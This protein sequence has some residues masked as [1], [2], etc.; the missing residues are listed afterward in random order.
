M[1]L[2]CGF[3]VMIK[4]IKSWSR[5]RQLDW[6]FSFKS[7]KRALIRCVEFSAQHSE[8]SG[9]S[10]NRP[11][12]YYASI[13]ALLKI[14]RPLAVAGA[15]PL[16]TVDAFYCKTGWTLSHVIQKILKAIPSFAD[17]NSTPTVTRIS[18]ISWVKASAA[19]MNPSVIGSGFLS[20][21]CVTVRWLAS[22]WI[23][24]TVIHV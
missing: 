6:P 9:D 14:C 23:H 20:S 16:F 19:K 18:R 1:D 12:V 3:G 2:T 4:P 17:S 10:I 5:K 15:V 13:L 21:T 24:G 22:K 7:V 11:L 8:A